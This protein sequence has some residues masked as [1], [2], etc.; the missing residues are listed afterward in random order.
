M[1]SGG[2][3]GVLVEWQLSTS[4]KNFL[5]HLSG[6]IENI[7]ISPTSSSYV[8][9]LGDNSAMILDE[10]MEPT[11][12][13]SGIQSQASPLIPSKDLLVSRAWAK[14]DYIARP[15]PAAINPVYPTKLQLCI[16]SGQ[17]ATLT[18]DSPSAPLLQ[19]FD[20]E[21]SRSVSKQALARTQPSE[22]HLTPKGHLIGEPRISHLVYSQNGKWLASVDEWLPPERD[23]HGVVDENCR[24]FVQ[25]RREIYLKFWAVGKDS[26]SLSLISR[27][28]SPHITN[29]PEEV[30]DVTPDPASEAFASIGNDG[31]VRIWRPKLRQQNGIIVKDA[32]GQPLQSWSS[33]GAISLRNTA[34]SDI[35]SPLRTTDGRKDHGSLMFSE[36]GSTLF[37]A[38]GGE[39]DGKI[40]IINSATSELRLTL[41]G[42]WLGHLISLRLLGSFAITL[43]SAELRVYNVVSDELHYGMTMPDMSNEHFKL[44]QMAV[45]CSTGHFAIAIPYQRSSELAVFS[46]EDPYPVIRKVVKQKILSLT[47]AGGSNGFIAVDDA[48]QVWALTSAADASSITLAMPLD[49]MHLEPVTEA[50]EVIEVEDED[51]DDEDV[52]SDNDELE[53]MDMDVDHDAPRTVVVNQQKL[54]DLFNAA[55]A[56]AMPPIEELF[57]QVANLIVSEPLV[58]QSA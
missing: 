2:A 49:E 9:H 20:L 24:Q 4:Q 13:V 34:R 44:S 43:S 31:I 6:A 8:L 53:E 26:G 52:P 27:I 55:P 14:R 18:G 38:F 47:D 51:N 46:P 30:F 33:T 57:Y 22:S 35:A 7:A 56:F 3:E 36:D 40:Y 15:A 32:S 17:H 11:A 41:D 45:N 42:M 25:E 10:R 21:A 12:Y 19:T 5:P 54:S 16:G 29:Q 48:A 39:D 58:P 23:I 28:N 1:I 37:V 50:E